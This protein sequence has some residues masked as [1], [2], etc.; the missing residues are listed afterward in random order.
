[1]LGIGE[2]NVVGLVFRGGKTSFFVGY[3]CVDMVYGLGGFESSF[4]IVCLVID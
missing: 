1:M 4:L 2:V 3:F